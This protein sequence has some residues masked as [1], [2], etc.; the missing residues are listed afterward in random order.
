MKK[1]EV[2]AAIVINNKKIFCTQ[3]LNIGEVALKWEFPGGKI[4][5]NESK[6]QA[7]E[8]EIKEELDSDISINE[9]YTTIEHQY[10]IFHL[11]MHCNKYTL[12]SDKITLK[13]HLDYCW[14]PIN[15]LGTLDWALAD[16]PIIRKLESGR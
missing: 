9:Y 13:E 2:V 15:K 1:I 16:W 10:E 3:R 5:V 7:L 4:D 8:R 11:T 14:L 6:A 12:I